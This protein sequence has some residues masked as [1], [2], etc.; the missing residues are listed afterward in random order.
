MYTFSNRLKI[1]AGILIV[2]G[3][4]GVTY[5]FMSSHK[6]LDQVKEMLAAEASHGGHGDSHQTEEHVVKGGRCSS[7]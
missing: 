2:L 5:G 6:T 7:R 1:F 3:L 4:L